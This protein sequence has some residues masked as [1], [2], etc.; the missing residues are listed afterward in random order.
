MQTPRIPYASDLFRKRLLNFAH[1][2][3]RPAPVRHG[4]PNLKPKNH[5]R[6]PFAF[7]IGAGLYPCP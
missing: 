7:R 5:H 2:A 3:R 1:H 6:E 4:T